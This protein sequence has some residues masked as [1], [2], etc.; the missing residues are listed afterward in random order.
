L[1][2]FVSIRLPIKTPLE[3]SAKGHLKYNLEKIE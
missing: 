2:G 3:S 1:E